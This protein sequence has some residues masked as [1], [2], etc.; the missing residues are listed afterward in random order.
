MLSCFSYIISSRSIFIYY[1][2]LLTVNRLS[3]VEGRFDQVVTREGH[4][5]AHLKNLVKQNG[6]IQRETKVRVIVQHKF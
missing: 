3:I 1:P 2:F 4:D 6:E 5:L